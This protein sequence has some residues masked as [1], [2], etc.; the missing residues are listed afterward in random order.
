[1]L[2]PIIPAAMVFTLLLVLLIGGFVVTYPV[3]RRLGRALEAYLDRQRSGGASGEEIATLR[4]Q[5]HA[6]KRQVDAV[7][8]KQD[9]VE[10]LLE[11][12]KGASLPGSEGEDDRRS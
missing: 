5:L 9:F 10:A 7:A 4:R 2:D 12:R 1:M 3:T 11:E 6:L 8:E